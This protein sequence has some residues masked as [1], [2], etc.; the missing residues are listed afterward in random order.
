MGAAV[1]IPPEKRINAEIVR[2]LKGPADQPLMMPTDVILDSKNRVYVADG[3]NNRVV[4]FSAEGKVDKIIVQPGGKKLNQPLGLGID[5]N[6]R[7]WIADTGEH[8]VV[9]VSSDGELI[10]T[11]DLPSSDLLNPFDPTDV[12]VT[13]DGLRSYIVDNNNHRLIIREN[14]NGQLK[15]I[16]RK[17]RA[18]GQFEYPFMICIGTEG[19]VYVN[20]VMGAR[21][22]RVSP[23]DRW[24]GLIGSW[25][26]ELG[27][28]YRPKGIASD[29]K[30]RIYVSDST[31]Q[32]IQ[33]FGPWGR[34]EGL[35]CDK[36]GQPL[37]FEHPM[38]MCFD[39]KNRLYVVELGAN[40]IAV[41][42][43]DGEENH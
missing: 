39:K 6:D 14:N 26:V 18:L 38:G 8:R 5:P 2:H 11:I 4:R 25:G 22:Q 27:Q 17:G 34:I 37:R 36:M 43:F 15:F 12:A 30:G 13:A 7:L 41:V 32:V 42:S 19:Y 28:F 20:E 35:L 40:Q 24:S 10:E 1:E 21:V 31:L 33:V 9:V 16:G 23:T 29:A 3:V